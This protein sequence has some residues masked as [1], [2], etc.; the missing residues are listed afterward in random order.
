[1][2][3]LLLMALRVYS[4]MLQAL[5]VLAIPVLYFISELRNELYERQ[6]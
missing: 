6:V 5:I 3:I 2:K 4:M 1:M